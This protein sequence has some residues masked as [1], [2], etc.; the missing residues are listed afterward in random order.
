M[1]RTIAT[2]FAVLLASTTLLTPTA[3]AADD[4]CVPETNPAPQWW[5]AALSPAQKEARWD[6]ADVRM[7]SSGAYTARVRSVWKPSQ[8]TVYFELS[9]QGDRA[10]HASGDVVLFALGDETGT[11]PEL[12]I[13][14]APVQDCAVNPAACDGDG[15]ALVGTSVLFSAATFS[16]TSITWS[17]LTTNNPSADFVVEHPWV[18]VEPVGSAYDWT[19]SF[20]LQVP[21]DGSGEIWPDLRIYGNAVM[22]ES[23]PTSYTEYEFPL[24]CTSSSVTSNDCLIYDGPGAQVPYDLPIGNMVDSWPV[25][26]SGMCI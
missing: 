19:L 24:L 8:E 3:H 14:F 13:R 5:N 1:H 17:K 22:R 21:V 23:G 10:L 7:L 15:V 20:A 16:G 4:L 6:D 12:F 26:E 25:L 11:L 2:T 18:V 9:V